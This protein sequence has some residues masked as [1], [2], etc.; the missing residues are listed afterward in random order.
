[1]TDNF[2]AGKVV[3]FDVYWEKG[4]GEAIT[5][6]SGTFKVLEPVHTVETV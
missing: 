5:F 6:V 4:V 2:T 1:M 3:Y